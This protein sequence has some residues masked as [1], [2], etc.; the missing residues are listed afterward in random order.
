MRCCLCIDEIDEFF[1]R[2]KPFNEK[3]HFICVC[4]EEY[5][6]FQ[7]LQLG[8]SLENLNSNFSVQNIIFNYLNLRLEMWCCSCGEER[9]SGA[10]YNKI[11]V[12]N[13][14]L[15]C[16]ENTEGSK[17]FLNNLIHYMCDRCW[18]AKRPPLN[19]NCKICSAEHEY[20]KKY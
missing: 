12:R 2:R 5:S 10:T 1:I 4:G 14:K 8:I 16:I 9:K 7:I 20:I 6:R 19:F 11:I 18:R 17:R 15:S 13:S 3:D